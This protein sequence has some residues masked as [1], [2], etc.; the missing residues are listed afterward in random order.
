MEQDLKG[1]L[2]NMEDKFSKSGQF[3]LMNE[4]MLTSYIRTGA[5]LKIWNNFGLNIPVKMRVCTLSI[6][7][8][9]VLSHL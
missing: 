9:L 5:A 6:P 8:L 4:A 2:S 3:L 1:S 7:V